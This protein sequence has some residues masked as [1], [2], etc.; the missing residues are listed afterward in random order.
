MAQVLLVDDSAFTRRVLKAAL[1]GAG[2]EIAEAENGRVGLDVLK[3]ISPDCIVLDNLMPIMEGHEFLAELR[4]SGSDLPVIVLTA[5]IQSSTRD[6]YV[7]MGISAFLNK[8]V[9]KEKLVE[10][11]NGV[12][13]EERSVLP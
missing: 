12:L 9:C 5:D 4:T 13:S 1:T 2:H 8:P 3:T 11:V 10:C 6:K 7:A